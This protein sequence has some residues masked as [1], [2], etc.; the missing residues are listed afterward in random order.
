MKQKNIQLEFGFAKMIDNRDI[1]GLVDVVGGYM[2]TLSVIYE[3]QHRLNQNPE[4]LLLYLER[5]NKGYRT[6]FYT[7]LE[8]FEK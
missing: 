5:Q 8:E 3:L 6:R 7:T 1:N 4:Y 2:G